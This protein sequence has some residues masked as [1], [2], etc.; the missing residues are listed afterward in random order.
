MGNSEV[1]ESP[2]PNPTKSA[3]TN[4]M[5]LALRAHEKHKN[6]VLRFHE[7]EENVS[8]SLGELLQDTSLGE[9]TFGEDELD[10]IDFRNSLEFEKVDTILR[11]A[12]KT[13]AVSPVSSEPDLAQDRAHQ[14][15]LLGRLN[16]APAHNADKL[17]VDFSVLSAKRRSQILKTFSRRPS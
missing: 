10:G 4:P 13:H 3:A 2:S 8:H 1:G 7:N 16:S 17:S 15:E 14:A 6:A 12:T 9:D 5:T 11:K